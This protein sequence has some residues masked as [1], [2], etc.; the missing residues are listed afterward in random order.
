MNQKGFANIVLIVVIVAII[1]VGGYFVLSKKSIT[2]STVTNQQQANNPATPTTQDT[3][4]NW[5]T[6]RN[7]KYGFEIKIPA[8]W[9]AI[10]SEMRIDFISPE[11]ASLRAQ[12]T[13]YCTDNNDLTLCIT[14][15]I[16]ADV[17]F[18]SMYSPQNIISQKETVFNNIKFTEYV[19]PSIGG[20]THYRT[21]KNDRIFDFVFYSNYNL[22]NSIFSNFKLTK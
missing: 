18:T 1:A 2:P 20:E 4:A 17:R 10:E 11:L 15:M 9:T 16:P 22:S 12:N 8:D 14:E 21:I 3:T 6:Y 5:K 13:I 19:E 7:D